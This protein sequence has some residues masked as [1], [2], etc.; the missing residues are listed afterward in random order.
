[1]SEEFPALFY[2]IFGNLPRQGPGDEASTLRALAAIPNPERIRNILDMGCGSGVPTLVLARNTSANVVALDNHAPFLDMLR[3][4]AATAGFG[5]RIRVVEGD[6]SKLEFARDSFD[7]IWSE[8]AIAVAGFEQGLTFWRPLLR[9]HGC[10]AVTDVCWFAADAPAEITDYLTGLYPGM[11][12]VSQCLQAIERSGFR[13]LDH[14]TLPSESWWTDYY[15]PLETELVRQRALHS[16]D[17]PAR[18]LLEVLQK[19]I[20][21]FRKYSD[22]YGYVF[23]VA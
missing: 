15:R 19:E 20:D 22:H 13:L 18:E 4:R 3:E 21:M 14:F 10:V 6:M 12:S 11:L 5:Q 17:P 1:M 2:E 16:D 8:G 7:L 23:Y 9:D